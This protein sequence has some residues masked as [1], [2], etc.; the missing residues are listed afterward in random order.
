ME[1]RNFDTELK[2]LEKQLN[3]VRNQ[4]SIVEELEN[5]FD[6]FIKYNDFTS[7][8]NQKVNHPVKYLIANISHTLARR[9]HSIFKLSNKK[10]INYY[11]IAMGNFY[12]LKEYI[13]FLEIALE[14][15]ILNK[16]NSNIEETSIISERV[17]NIVTFYKSDGKLILGKYLDQEVEEF[18]NLI[19]DYNNENLIKTRENYSFMVDC[20]TK[21]DKNI[22]GQQWKYDNDTRGLRK[23]FAIFFWKLKEQKEYVELST[24]FN[25]ILEYSLNNVEKLSFDDI[26][27]IKNNVFN[28]LKKFAADSSNEIEEFEKVQYFH[29]T[30][31]TI[32]T[33]EYEYKKL[34]KEKIKTLKISTDNVCVK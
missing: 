22:P 11:K 32:E 25:K 12:E 8:L 16:D 7:M 17:R 6:E 1:I 23:L 5:E 3:T 27:T 33:I 2:D 18:A 24:Q 10:T 20:E 34:V 31:K 13:P 21:V 19:Y 29:E 30:S 28:S 14:L 26:Q 9:N 4:Q 15:K